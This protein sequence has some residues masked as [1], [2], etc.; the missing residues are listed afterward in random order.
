MYIIGHYFI[1]P[2]HQYNY[3]PPSLIDLLKSPQVLKTGR[4]VTGDLNKLKR[5]YGLSYCPGTA[6]ELGSFCRKRGYIDNGTASLSEIAESVLGSKLKKQN[7]DSNWEA[8]DLSSPQLYY[9]ALDAWVSLAIYTKLANVRTIGKLVQNPAPKEAF[10][11]VYPSDQWSYPVAFGVVI[12][13][14]S[15][16]HTYIQKMTV[17]IIN[18]Y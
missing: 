18:I 3:I 5:D 4:N 7:R 12:K 1:I 8:Q 13:S 15:V 17:I 16:S 10:I 9:A 6:L 2:I 14:S 11:S